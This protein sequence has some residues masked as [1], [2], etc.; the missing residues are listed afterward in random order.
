VSLLVHRRLILGVL[1]DGWRH[2]PEQCVSARLDPRVDQISGDL[3]YVRLGA[4]APIFVPTRIDQRPG[5]KAEA[6]NA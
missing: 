6:G 4:G 3:T 1:G 2:R 5:L